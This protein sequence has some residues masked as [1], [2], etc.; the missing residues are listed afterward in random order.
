M[1]IRKPKDEEVLRISTTDYL[2]LLSNTVCVSGG[3]S[4]MI[5][6]RWNVR[7][8]G[9][10]AVGSEY[11]AG[12]TC[13]DRNVRAGRALCMYGAGKQPRSMAEASIG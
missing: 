12:T 4:R 11:Y 10:N 13:V 8:H 2:S 1:L 7:K 3:I 9:I 5:R 6:L